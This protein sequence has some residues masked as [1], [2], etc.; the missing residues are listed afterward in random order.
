MEEYKVYRAILSH[1]MNFLIWDKKGNS[2]EVVIKEPKS[3]QKARFESHPSHDFCIYRFDLEEATNDF[4]SFFN[5]EE[6]ST[7]KGL[8]IFCDYIILFTDGYRLYIILVEMK[9]SHTKDAEKQLEASRVFMEYIK[10]T[11]IRLRE[12]D[13]IT[14]FNEESV[15]TLK[16]CL[17]DAIKRTP[18]TNVKGNLQP[19]L[20]GDMLVLDWYGVHIETIVREWLRLK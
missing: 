4:L 3:E 18:K 12:Q 10:Q 14:Q 1:R 15:K 2:S 20:E 8:R 5:E 9:R 6:N 7:I 11:A 17:K 19:K 13:Y 16:L